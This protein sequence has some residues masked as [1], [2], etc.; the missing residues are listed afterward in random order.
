MNNKVLRNRKHWNRTGNWK[1]NRFETGTGGTG[2]ENRTG[3]TG[4]G[5]NFFE[6]EREPP[7]KWNRSADQSV[8]RSVGSVRK[9][10]KPWLAGTLVIGDPQ[11]NGDKSEEIVD[12]FSF[13]LGFSG[14]GF[15]K[16]IRAGRP[17]FFGLV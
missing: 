7:R 6:S 1:P 17:H 12:C 8:D 15:W 4:T 9:H 5:F 10:G 11:E 13:F 16:I 2:R 3:R 14:R